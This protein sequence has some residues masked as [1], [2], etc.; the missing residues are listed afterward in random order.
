MHTYNTTERI[1]G[2]KILKQS[3]FETL[4]TPHLQKFPDA[5]AV[6]AVKADWEETP[7]WV[8]VM[9]YWEELYALINSTYYSK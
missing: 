6:E 7:E 4:W 5:A 9:Y 8:Y 2:D 1:T 3:L